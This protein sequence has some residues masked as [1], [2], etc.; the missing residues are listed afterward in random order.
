MRTMYEEVYGTPG[1][2]VW[3]DIVAT[4][5]DSYSCFIPNADEV[6][7]DVQWLEEKR[8]A[9]FGGEPTGRSRRNGPRIF[10]DRR[11][12]LR[13]P[14]HRGDHAAGATVSGKRQGD[15]P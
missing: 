5:G 3:T 13:R 6:E 2:R 4:C 9:E 14:R 11:Y 1:P 8:H 15:E 12:E 10:K 7:L